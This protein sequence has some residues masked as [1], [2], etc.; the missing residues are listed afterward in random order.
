MRANTVSNRKV[1]RESQR[2]ASTKEKYG[3]PTSQS[4]SPP[5]V[6]IPFFGNENA[7]RTP[8]NKSGPSSY[9]SANLGALPPIPLT[10]STGDSSSFFDST[11]L[12]D[13]FPK[14]P[15]NL[16]N[17]PGAPLLSGFELGTTSDLGSRRGLGKGETIPPSYR[18]HN[19][20][21]YR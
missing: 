12:F 14:V 10:P 8:P 2:G 5:R 15:Q 18:L 20:E 17:G 21:F 19:S 6:E 3:N 1:S 9:L 7:T 13:A 4:T 11:E 16:P